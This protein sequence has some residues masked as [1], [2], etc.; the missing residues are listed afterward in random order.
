[1]NTV[2]IE[3]RTKSDT[4]LLVDFS[5]RIGADVKAGTSLKTKHI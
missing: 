1:M 2:V 5:K 4:R 3:P